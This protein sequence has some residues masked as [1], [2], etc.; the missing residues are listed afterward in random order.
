MLQDMTNMEASL[1][2]YVM[3]GTFTHLERSKNSNLTV[4]K[5]GIVRLNIHHVLIAS[6]SFM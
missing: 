6:V 2:F 1:V 5:T 4:H 3:V